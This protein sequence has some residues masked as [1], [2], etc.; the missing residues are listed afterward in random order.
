MLMQVSAGGSGTRRG[1]MCIPAP[2]HTGWI[3]SNPNPSKSSLNPV[4]SGQ[5]VLLCGLGG[6]FPSPTLE[7]NFMN[8]SISRMELGLQS[9]LPVKYI[10]NSSKTVNK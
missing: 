2:P 5:A 10:K 8:I 4:G 7:N 3:K 9:R 1:K 6:F